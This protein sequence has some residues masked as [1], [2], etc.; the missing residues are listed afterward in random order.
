MLVKGAT[1]ILWNSV[2]DAGEVLLNGFMYILYSILSMLNSFVI[3]HVRHDE[4]SIHVVWLCHL[5]KL[6]LSHLW[7]VFQFLM[8]H[9]GAKPESISNTLEYIRR[10]EL[11][12]SSLNHILKNTTLLIQK[13]SW[14]Y[15]EWL[16]IDFHSAVREITKSSSTFSAINISS[17]MM[18]FFQLHDTIKMKSNHTGIN[19]NHNNIAIRCHIMI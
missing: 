10:R 18:W 3:V 16:F 8:S 9:F 1:G 14:K 19:Y 6:I 7:N 13:M 2:R 15:R 12:V 17:N 5:S 4:F 11:E